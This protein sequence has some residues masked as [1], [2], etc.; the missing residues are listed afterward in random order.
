MSK[1]KPLL[2][3]GARAYIAWNKGMC[4]GKLKPYWVLRIGIRTTRSLK[5]DS[6]DLFH[7]GGNLSEH[8]LDQYLERRHKK[9][10]WHGINSDTPPDF[11][12]WCSNKPLTVDV[13]SGHYQEQM[14]F[15]DNPHGEPIISYPAGRLPKRLDDYI[16]GA[17]VLSIPDGSCGVAIWGVIERDRLIALNLPVLKGKT[18]PY[19]AI[20]LAKF[21]PR[22]LARLINS[23]DKC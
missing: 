4:L 21:S 20:P 14:D 16:I 7:E 23:T 2:F 1:D 15:V 19:V 13:H 17:S 22:R 18:G 12:F 6:I 5:A 9:Y 11:K 8:A 3:K 10:W